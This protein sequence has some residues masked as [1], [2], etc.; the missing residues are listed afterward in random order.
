MA[1]YKPKMSAKNFFSKGKSS[2]LELFGKII[3]PN[4]I[5]SSKLS[6]EEINCVTK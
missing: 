5:K 3:I 4:S 6:C 1:P 2:D